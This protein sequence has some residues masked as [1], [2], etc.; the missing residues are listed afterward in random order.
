MRMEEQKTTPTPEFVRGEVVE[1]KSCDEWVKATYYG[2][3]EG[4]RYPYIAKVKTNSG[5]SAWDHIRKLPKQEAW[6]K[7]FTREQVQKY[8]GK[9]K[10]WIMENAIANL[11]IKFCEDNGM[12]EE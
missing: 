12:L 6:P 10:L 4:E 9:L 3:I 8:A 5:Y 11:L 2:T 1:V 7:K